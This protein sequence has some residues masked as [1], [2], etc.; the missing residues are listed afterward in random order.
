MI[1][2]GSDVGTER[3]AYSWLYEASLGMYRLS[4]FKPPVP[5]W[6]H[7]VESRSDHFPTQYRYI[8]NTAD[9]V[10]STQTEGKGERAIKWLSIQYSRRL[11]WKKWI[12]FMCHSHLPSSLRGFFYPFWGFPMFFNIQINFLVL[13][14][15]QQKLC[16]LY[17]NIIILKSGK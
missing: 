8:V 1:G 2:R 17:C 15:V 9:W 13:K 12:Y 4:F 11:I 16:L 14:C 6:V 3:R 5:I 7:N 10:S